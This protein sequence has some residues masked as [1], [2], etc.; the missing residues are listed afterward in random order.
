MIQRLWLDHVY[1]T[2]MFILAALGPSNPP[3]VDVITKRLML[4]QDQL[5]VA[6]LPNSTAKDKLVSLLKQHISIAGD[7]VTGLG[8]KAPK[9]KIQALETDWAKNADEISDLLAQ[10]L[11]LSLDDIRAAMRMHLE[12]TS[13]EIK[14]QLAKD[15]AASVAAF[16]AV[17]G[18]IV[19]MSDMISG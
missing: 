1:W 13:A 10:E 15:E 16:D 2:R 4:N 7:I 14:A 5:G 19:N 6:I 17:E 3:L 18:H 8:A 9:E 11:K 12:T